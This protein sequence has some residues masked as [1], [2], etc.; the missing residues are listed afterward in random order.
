MP[1]KVWMQGPPGPQGQQ[2]EPGAAATVTVGTVTTGEPGTD[3][4]V[5]NSGTENAAV[6]N[7]T[8]PTGETGAVG[9][10]GPQGPRG[11]KGDPGPAGAGVPDGGTVGQLLG[12]T[13]TGT[14]WIDPPQSGV[15]SD[16][17]QNDEAQPD[18]VKNRPFYSEIG[19]VTVE[20]V[21]DTKL[22]GFPIFAVGDTVTV[23]V[24]GVEHSLVAYDDDGFTTIGDT[25]ISIDNGEGQLGWQFY[26]SSGSEKVNF[27]ATEA[28]TVSYLSSVYH[29]ID[30]KYLPENIA[31]KS[32]V[33]FAKNKANTA[34]TTANAAQTTANAA[35]TTANA[36]QTTANTALERVVEP[37]TRNMQMAPLYKNGGFS[38]WRNVTQNILYDKTEGYFFVN[39]FD[40]TAL[41]GEDMPKDVFCANVYVENS[42][43]TAFLSCSV[44][45]GNLW[46]VSGFAVITDEH[47]RTGEILYVSSNTISKNSAK[48]LFLTFRAPDSMLLKSSTTDSAKQFRIT[49]DDSGTISATEVT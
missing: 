22:D 1:E 30:A 10:V 8:I 15:Q 25:A 28:H 24:D 49:V 14:A 38:A 13:E 34:Q 11:D 43:A 45:T 20:N 16:W 26:V 40:T 4:I 47:S 23:T 33:E 29:T 27:Y 42:R 39:G 48:G 9:A 31:T 36:A 35:Q 19:I 6:L 7:F 44:T 5:T 46:F 21:S 32:E 3:V 37:Y 2:G 17:N 41:N 18:Y 12:K